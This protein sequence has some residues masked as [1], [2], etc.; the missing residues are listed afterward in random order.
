MIGQQNT[1]E[2]YKKTIRLKYEEEKTGV[3]SSFFINPSRAKLRK[4]CIE[5][6]KMNINHDDF[7]SFTIFFGFNFDIG[8]LNKLKSQT[9]KFRPIETFFKGKTDL[10]DI[11]GINI[12]ALLVDFNPRPFNRY[13]QNK[14]THEINDEIFSEEMDDE[15]EGNSKDLGVVIKEEVNNKTMRKRIIIPLAFVSLFFMGYTVKNIIF[16]SKECMQWKENHYEAVDCSNDKLGIGQLTLIV[17]IDDK[18]MKLEKLDSKAGLEF[19]KNEKPIVW[20]YKKDGEIE[21]FNQP[22]FHPET[23]KQLKPITPYIIEKYK[24]RGKD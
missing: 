17:P 11:E 16:P 21:L 4:L 5:R 9:D 6:M 12:A 19:F 10:S 24:L 3:Y 20:Y 22:G 13:R 2:E 18:I 7:S 15:I 14:G 23:G 1:L 8:N